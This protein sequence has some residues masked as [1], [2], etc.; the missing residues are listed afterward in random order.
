MKKIFSIKGMHCNSCSQRIE[1]E[2][3]D[4]VNHIDVSYS[5]EKAEIEYDEDKITEKEIKDKISECGYE[6]GGCEEV[7]HENNKES[8]DHKK[9]QT[10][11]A[12]SNMIAWGIIMAGVVLIGYYIYNYLTGLNLT[13]PGS[14][15][16]SGIVLLF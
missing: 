2:L 10:K 16:N 14:G 13:I 3:K 1:D 7:G 4:K 15:D 5:K 12:S 11:I 8:H 6:C 9:L